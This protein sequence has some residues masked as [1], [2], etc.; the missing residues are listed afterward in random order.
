MTDSSLATLSLR[1]LIAMAYGTR[2][3]LADLQG[4]R[5]KGDRSPDLQHLIDDAHRAVELIDNFLLDLARKDQQ[6]WVLFDLI[7]ATHNG[8]IQRL[9]QRVRDI[10][11]PR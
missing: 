9:S 11:P 7:K 2:A 4:M 1:E 8:S 3:R 10:L 6:G 5:L